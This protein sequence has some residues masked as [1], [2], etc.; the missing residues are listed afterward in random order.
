MTP[1]GFLMMKNARMQ[2]M[3]RRIQSLEE[4]SELAAQILETITPGE[5]ATLLT[6]S[7][8]LGAGKTAFVKAIAKHLGVPEEVTS[9]TF[10]IMK[11]YPVQH[12][13]LKTLTHIDAYRIESDDEMRVLGFSEL[14]KD[15]TQLIAVEWPERIAALIPDAAVRIQIKLR[16]EER[17]ITF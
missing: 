12:S 13:F 9:P 5:S 6:L 4:L 8:D 10:V 1:G 11:S 2:L 16:G 3:E 14:L 15:P 17:I 7:G